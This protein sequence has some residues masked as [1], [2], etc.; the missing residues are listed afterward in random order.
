MDINKLKKIREDANLSQSEFAG[1]IGVGV[2]TY[3]AY[4]NGKQV[5][6]ADVI[7]RICQQFDVSSD[8]LL[9]INENTNSIRS[10]S[11]FAETVIQLLKSTKCEL[12][13]GS[14]TE[15]HTEIDLPGCPGWEKYEVANEDYSL[16]LFRDKSAISLLNKL[17]GITEFL[18][19]KWFNTLIKGFKEDYSNKII[20]DDTD[21]IPDE[22]Y[23][24]IVAHISSVVKDPPPKDF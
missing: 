8:W 9:D 3:N 2:S 13:S 5:P 16:L 15:M 24:E 19:Q 6:R 22:I 14:Y 18:P 10:Y 7:K 17:K 1:K 20:T 21:V 11:D 4:E 23:Y 12:I